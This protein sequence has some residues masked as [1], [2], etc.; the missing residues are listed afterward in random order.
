MHVLDAC[1]IHVSLSHCA[2]EKPVGDSWSRITIIKCLDFDWLFFE[3]MSENN[4]EI[5][6]TSFSLILSFVF[7]GLLGFLKKRNLEN[8][9]ISLKGTE[10]IVAQLTHESSIKIPMFFFIG[11]S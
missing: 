11:K 9:K 5:L 10:E 4:Y 7:V 8:D 2:I 3:I 6:M 1:N